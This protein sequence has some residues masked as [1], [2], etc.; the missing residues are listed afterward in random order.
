MTQV[1]A[2]SALPDLKTSLRN[3]LALF[4][5]KPDALTEYLEPYTQGV[6]DTLQM[7]KDEYGDGRFLKTLEDLTLGL[8]LKHYLKYDFVVGN[9]PYVRVQ[10]L[11]EIQ[12]KYWADK[13]IWAK[14][15]FDIFIPFIERVLYGD[16]PWLEQGGKLGY[17]VPNRFLNTNYAASLRE[18]LPKVARILSITDFKAVTFSPPEEDQASRLFKEA[19]VYPAILIAQRGS[20]KGQPYTFKTARFYPKAASIHPADAIKSL[21]REYS[22]GADHAHLCTPQHEYANVFTQPSNALE[23]NGWHLMPDAERRVFEKLEVI[24][25]TQDDAI[26]AK[27]PEDKKRR[28]KN[29]TATESGGFAGIQTSLDS[30]MVFKQLDEDTEKG[31]LYVEP[32]GGGEPFWVEKKSLRPFLF[33]KDVERWHVGWEGW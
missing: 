27:L 18:G 14:G 17:I 2:G 25:E 28:L 5:T 30:H 22:N 23:A 31:L 10:K 15:N 16:R 20:P 24:G 29:Y 1:N 4:E 11:P 3:E 8:V 32:R 19:M 33:G 12:K 26:K 7:L 21:R 9:P 13:Y 6:W